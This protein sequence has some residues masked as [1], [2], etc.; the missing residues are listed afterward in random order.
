MKGNASMN[1]IRLEDFRNE[2][3]SNKTIS[4]WIGMELIQ[5]IDHLGGQ[6]VQVEAQM[7]ILMKERDLYKSELERLKKV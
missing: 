4:S 2:I 7:R 1:Q 6:L 3:R 5:C